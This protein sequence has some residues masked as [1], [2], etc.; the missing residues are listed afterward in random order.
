MATAFIVFGTPDIILGAVQQDG[1]VIRADGA[2]VL[3]IETAI[4]K[5][6]ETHGA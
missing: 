1:H 4:P 6:G 2:G 3:I 5:D